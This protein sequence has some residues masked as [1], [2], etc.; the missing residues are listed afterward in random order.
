MKRRWINPVLP[1]LVAVAG[2]WA[3]AALETVST[4]RAQQPVP[5]QGVKDVVEAKRFVIR[6]E[7]GQARIEIGPN[8]KGN[9]FGVR[10]LDGRGR[11]RLNVAVASDGDLAGVSLIDQEG[12]N[13]VGLILSPEQTGVALHGRH[14]AGITET[15]AGTTAFVVGQGEVDAV[16]LGVDEDGRPIR[17]P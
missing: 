10:I 4:S 16:L 17:K 14:D 9:A 15:A 1:P 7:Q 2:V 8:A 5:Y 13:R 3:Y 11:L 12:E 6:D